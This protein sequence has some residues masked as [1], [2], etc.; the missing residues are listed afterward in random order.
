M[1]DS[2]PVEERRNGPVQHPADAVLGTRNRF[3]QLKG[4]VREREKSRSR[5]ITA[6]QQERYDWVCSEVPVTGR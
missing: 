1:F 6:H 3:K 5:G 4:R 2:S